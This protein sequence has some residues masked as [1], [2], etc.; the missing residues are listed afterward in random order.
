ML[1]SDSGEVL[2]QALESIE[3]LWDELIVGD[4]GSTD[5]TREILT[6]YKARIVEQKEGNLG[7][8]KQELVRKAKGEWILVLDSDERVSEELYQEIK[9]LS[10]SPRRS[11]GL[12]ASRRISLPPSE[13]A[14]TVRQCVA[15]RIPYQNYVFGKPV[16]YGG[17]KYSKVRMFRKGKGRVETVPL[18][19]EVIV[20][21]RVGD[22][23]GVLLHHS[24]RSVPQLFGKFTQYAIT[25]AREKKKNRERPS[26]QKLF[27]YGPHMFWA[28]FISDQGYKDGLGG[29]VL[30][31]AF[32]YMETLTYWLLLFK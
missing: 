18:H 6:Q 3:G 32:F 25:L 10:H 22:L 17:E 28:R 20:T 8:R 19:E 15:Y 14:S 2:K 9:S 21:G 23:H 16:Y 29:F 5:G 13:V 1:T 4:A 30:A 7:A 12:S 27:L 24:Y 26:L 11:H 31:I